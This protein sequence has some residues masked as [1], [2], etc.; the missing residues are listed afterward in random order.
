MISSSAYTF[1]A[2][3]LVDGFGRVFFED[4]EVY[5]AIYDSES[6][7]CNT[8][9][10][11]PLFQKL[12]ENK[13]IP[14]TSLTTKQV[15]G[16]GMVLHHEKLQEILPHEWS[17]DM[18]K[19][20]TIL[21]WNINNL[22]NEYGYELKDGHCFNIL[23][24]GTQPVLADIGS[25][26]IRNLPDSWIA[27]EEYLESFVIPLNC[28]SAGMIYFTRAILGNNTA[29]VTTIPSQTLGNSG[30]LQMIPNMEL[31]FEFAVKRKRIFRL[32]KDNKLLKGIV[33]AGNK[34]A[35]LL[36]SRPSAILHFGLPLGPVWKKSPFFNKS[37]LLNNLQ[38]LPAPGNNSAWQNYH[39]QAFA[40]D[41]QIVY[42]DRFH[43]IADLIQGYPD[44]RYVIDLAGNE[45]YFCN[46]LAENQ[47]IEKII[48]SDFDEN[49]VN[50][51]YQRFKM[52]HD[53][54]LH[55]VL[56]N[57]MLPRDPSDTSS[58]LKCDL[59]V[60][61]A[62]THHLIL[63]SRFSIDAIF[64]RVSLYSRK[65][66]LIEFMPIG[67]WGGEEDIKPVPD[68]YHVD[69]FR[70]HFQKYFFLVHEEQTEKNRIMFFGTIRK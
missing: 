44:I 19:D 9:I 14:K 51:A 33:S 49:A 59:A 2:K 34:L 15:P 8:L 69:W 30:A 24:R 45:G 60:A 52:Q 10:Q 21:V 61:L 3:S 27:Y 64:E 39:R 67:L 56:L 62:V 63:G 58:R 43:K 29:G 66:V 11:S 23:F 40:K 20:A 31:N 4:G 35:S 22:C 16:Y 12:L 47:Q 1:S 28:W 42:S 70:E 37:S 50:S 41:G 38:Q 25:I 48:L 13:W 32:K 65:Y 6:G 53:S 55:T 5:R 17:F 36:L 68:W 57:F 46:L 7:F 26:S 18:M 54:R